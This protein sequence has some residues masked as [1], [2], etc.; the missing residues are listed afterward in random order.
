VVVGVAATVTSEGC[1][2]SERARD[3]AAAWSLILRRAAPAVFC[4]Y[5]CRRPPLI[6]AAGRPDKGV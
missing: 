6:R 5:R 3:G 4:E 1:H 2:E